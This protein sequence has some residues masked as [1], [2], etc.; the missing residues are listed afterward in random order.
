VE[1]QVVLENGTALSNET[2][3]IRF[4]GSSE[5]VRTDDDGR[6][7]V[8]YRP[9]RSPTGPRT[10]QVAYRPEIGSPYLGSNANFSIDV[11]QVTANL[12]VSTNTRTVQFGD[13]F[14]VTGRA[15]VNGTPVP[16]ASV[17]VV[18]G[19]ESLG[20]VVT[21][22]DGRYSLETEFPE[23]I[24][25]GNN[26]VRTVIVP[27]DRAVSSAGA[28][29]SVEVDPT[30]VSLSVNASSP[31]ES[32]VRITGELA[33][34]DGRSL[35]GRTVELR[36][37]GTTVATVQTNAD[38]SFS[39]TVSVSDSLSGTVTVRAVYDEPST[40]LEQ[41]SARTRL[42]LAE[43]EVADGEVADGEF[44]SAQKI[45]QW[46]LASPELL[47]GI[48]VALGSLLSI[49]WLVRR[50]DDDGAVESPYPSESATATEDTADRTVLDRAASLLS[51]DESEAAI[52]ALYAAVRGSI[53]TDDSSL[54][55]WEFYAAVNDRL[56]QEAAGT[57]ERL[58]EEY[59]RVVYSPER[60]ETETAERLLDESKR[61]V[62]DDGEGPSRAD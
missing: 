30:P 11:T 34:A 17:R 5:T 38:G 37:D 54:T 14:A 28:N 33:T 59:E 6:F 58:T 22:A 16:G 46:I 9:V 53:G 41:A 48:A 44:S 39:Q 56:T 43:G 24:A 2:V 49:G 26:V 35:G 18:V 21:D 57:L 47:G 42:D 62:D 7:T 61:L 31:G 20:T 8:D 3:D 12:S 27:G 29:T 23:S 15:L 4:R 50:R 40:N 32:I 60:T 13:E 52:R 1:G 10:V 25:T 55:H 36:V 45:R 19:G 51:A